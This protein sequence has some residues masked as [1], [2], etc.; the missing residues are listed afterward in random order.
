MGKEKIDRNKIIVTIVLVAILLCSVAFS[1]V[2]AKPSFYKS[3][4]EYLDQKQSDSKAL[5]IASSGLAL[6]LS[7]LPDDVG[8]PIANKFADISGYFAVAL[9]G[10]LLEKYLLTLTGWLVFRFLIP[11]SCLVYIGCIYLKGIRNFRKV[12]AK[13]LLFALAIYLVIPFSVKVSK[14]IEETYAISLDDV[15]QV[16]EQAPEVSKETNKVPVP[17]QDNIATKKYD[18]T[19]SGIVE[20]TRDFLNKAEEKV[21]EI[22]T[23]AGDSVSSGIDKITNSASGLLQSA[24]ETLSRL[25]EGLMITVITSCV[26]PIFVFILLIWLSNVILGLNIDPMVI[27]QGRPTVAHRHHSQMPRPME[28]EVL[29]EYSDEENSEFAD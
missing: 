22:V 28:G 8:T 6:T 15:K 10:L 5:I 26:I 14:L 23:S 4:I 16:E 18:L 2:A 25:F 9:G 29:L 19:L 20:A 27:V 3:Q 21:N 12:A 11:L 17:V 13:I 1:F 7:L 24:K